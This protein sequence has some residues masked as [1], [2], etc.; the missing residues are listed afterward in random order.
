[1]APNPPFPRGSALDKQSLE[2]IDYIPDHP[3]ITLQQDHVRMFL[4]AELATKILDRMYEWLWLCATK[5]STRIDTLHEHV[6]KGRT[7]LVTEDPALHLVWFNDSICVK[8]MPLALMN[9]DFWTRFL[10]AQDEDEK[11]GQ[12]A[13]MFDPK[14]AL[15][16]LRSYGRI[17][18]HRSDLAIAIEKGLLPKDFEWLDWE[19]FIGG[20]RTI[21]DHEV[22]RRYHFGQFRLS[23]LNLLI[24][25]VRPRDRDDRGN[26]R[27]YY[28][29]Y[30]STA[31]YLRQFVEAGLFVFASI[32]LILSAM[33]VVLSLP[34]EPDTRVWI[35][36]SSDMSLAFWG[37]C[38]M[39]L[40]GLALSWLLLL[41]GPVFYM[42]AQQ[43]FGYQKKRLFDRKNQNLAD[44]KIENEQA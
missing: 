27:H 31:A 44:N 39:V 41:G 14:V 15:G 22:A 28:T 9:H 30:W 33:Q 23:R 6:L 5:D 29:M 26:N 19:R 2:I 24:R 25:F 18:K 43:I 20:T 7:V 4:E 10:A 40:V 17:I 34:G 35:R 21:E 38:V 13:S 3:S 8:P 16:F 42:T 37:F 32:S 12:D 11:T 36:N 1:M